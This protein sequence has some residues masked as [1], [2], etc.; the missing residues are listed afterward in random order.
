MNENKHKFKIGAY[1]LWTALTVFI[2]ALILSF[3]DIGEIFKV[4]STVNFK[5]ILYALLCILIYMALY[6]LSLCILTKARGCDIK[7]TTTYNIAMTEHFFNGVTPFATG[8]QPFQAYAYSK[9]K[10]TPSEST[11]LLL[12]NFLVFMLVTNSFAAL[13][14]IYFERFVTDSAMTIIAIIGFTMNFTVLAVTFALGNSKIARGI[15]TRFIDFLLKFKWI[16]KLLA[17]KAPEL[18]QYFVNVQ[19]AFTDLRK[20]WG[21]FILAFITKAASMLFYYATTYFILH[22]FGVGVDISDLFFVICGTSF[23]ITMVVFL[24]T[25][26]SSGGIEFAFQSIFASIASSAAVI[27]YGGM[28]VWR[29]LTYYL[30]M[31]ISLGFYVALEIGFSKKRKELTTDEKNSDSLLR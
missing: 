22:A 8:G 28:L 10:V 30:V 17:P 31:L 6:P 27:S 14:L 5:Y 25:P 23:A 11:S 1:I 20:K 21:A 3:N 4:I 12:M 13:A 26:G 15:L 19:E 18:K 29:L 2:L 7:M 24:P 16:A 9:A